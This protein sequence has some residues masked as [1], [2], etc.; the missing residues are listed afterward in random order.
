MKKIISIFLFLCSCF[1]ILYFLIL[2]Y[3]GGR[4]Y[5]DN[6][7]QS[8]AILVLGAKSY[9]GTKY[10]PCL[11]A[12]VEHAVNLFNQGFAKKIIMS[13]GDD[14]EDNKNEAE[15]MKKIAQELKVSGKDIITEKRSTSSYENILFSKTIMKKQNI[16]SVIVVTEPFHSPRAFLV[17][18]K[19][20]LNFSVSPTL[21]SQCW[22][23]WKFGSRYFLREPLAIIQYF[24][25]G[26]I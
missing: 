2:F 14:V 11:E 20:E 6:K 10:N 5:S 25:Q 16:K 23:R 13:G 26:K 8:D 7:K 22:L 18:K 1:L 4:V 3:V 9:K 19:A 12:R 15:T 17:A 21:T 24:I